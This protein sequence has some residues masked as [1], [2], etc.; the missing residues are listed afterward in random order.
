MTLKGIP[1][2][3]VKVNKKSFAITTPAGK[4]TRHTIKIP[5]Q[6]SHAIW[7]QTFQAF[8]ARYKYVEVRRNN[9][10]AYYEHTNNSH[11]FF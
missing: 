11:P 8:S 1:I 6:R 10:T 9:I 7:E 3:D 2:Y 5:A 4:T